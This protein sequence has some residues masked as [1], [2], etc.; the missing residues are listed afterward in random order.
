M[1]SFEDIKIRKVEHNEEWYFSIIDV[2]E[3]LIDSSL[4]S[5]YWS[6]L[7][8]KLQQESGNNELYDKIVKLKFLAP[9]GRIRSTDCANIKTAFQKFPTFGK[10]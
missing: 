2:L 9:D 7:K 6:D 1:V 10:L 4:P 3:L 5:R 8:R